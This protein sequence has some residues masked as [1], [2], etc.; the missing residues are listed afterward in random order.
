MV[1]SP[2]LEISLYLTDKHSAIAFRRAP[3]FS[4]RLDHR[5]IICQQEINLQVYLAFVE[6]LDP[7]LFELRDAIEGIFTT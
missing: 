3:N 7:L 6:N 5:L 2:V 4:Q 1:W